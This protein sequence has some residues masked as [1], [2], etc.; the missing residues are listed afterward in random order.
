MVLVK[1]FKEPSVSIKL[2]CNQDTVPNTGQQQRL[3]LFFGETRPKSGSSV[4][5]E[6][7][8]FDKGRKRLS[9]TEQ[10]FQLNNCGST[11]LATACSSVCHNIIILKDIN[12]KICCFAS[13]RM[14]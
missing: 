14:V 4:M 13:S 10:R 8:L 3:W 11:T 1:D 7:V 5:W 9:P 6:G 2:Y 12:I